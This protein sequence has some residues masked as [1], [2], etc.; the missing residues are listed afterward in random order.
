MIRRAGAIAALLLSAALLAGCTSAPAPAETTEP[1]AGGLPFEAGVIAAM[2]DS[3][4]VGVAACGQN[5][6]CPSASWTTGEDET[7]DSV[8]RRAG[9]AV[10]A[11]PTIENVAAKG[12][13]SAELPR[14]AEKAVAVSPDLVT[15]LIGANDVCR[16]NSSDITTP[17]AF[18]TSVTT[19]LATLSTGA[20]DA[21]IFVS[22][23]PNLLDFFETER[24]DSEAVS[25][26][27][28]SSNCNSL[29]YE[30][31]SDAADSVARRTNVSDTIDAYNAIL[32]EACGAVANCVY[33]GGAL[34]DFDVTSDDISDVDHFHPSIAGQAKLADIAW[35]ALMAG[36][37]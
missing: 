28:G 31:T 24:T 5:K 2:G 17:D 18:R 27:S 34:H 22:S 3:I 29:L 7:V 19:S 37:S 9:E 14:Q 20:P 1:A 10:G 23:V 16:K 13:T 21:T 8:A 11:V 15:V 12:A 25:R 35:T 30:P 32:A 33:D 6:P 4:S 26:W 36:V